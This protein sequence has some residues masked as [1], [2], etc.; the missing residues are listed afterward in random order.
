M[1][2][3]HTDINK[4]EPETDQNKES[5][6]S[7]DIEDF[8][9]NGNEDD[10]ALPSEEELGNSK[11]AVRRKIE[12]YWEKRRLREQLGDFVEIDFDF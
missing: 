4:P 1:S 2:Q 9:G 8:D 6:V 5:S 11:L 10:L 12:L 7:I 3:A